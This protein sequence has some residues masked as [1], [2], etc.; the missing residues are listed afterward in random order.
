VASTLDETR[1]VVCA[2]CERDVRRCLQSRW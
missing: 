2:R 1:G